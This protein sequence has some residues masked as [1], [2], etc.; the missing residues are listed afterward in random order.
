M[1]KNKRLHLFKFLVAIILI[2]PCMFV[3]SA[4][5]KQGEKG[6][7]G[8]QG[9]QG[10][11]GDKGDNGKDAE[12][13]N[14]YELYLSAKESGEF[15]G[16]YLD[17]IKDY[18]D[19]VYDNSAVVANKAVAST[20]SIDAYNGVKPAKPTSGSGVIFSLDEDGNAFIVT[21]YHVTYYYNP[22]NH[23]AFK[24]YDIYLYGEISDNVIHATYVGGSQT[25]DLAV[26]Y[27]SNSEILKNSNAQSI[28][29]STG[30][31]ILGSSVIASGNANGYGL[32]VTKGIIS[33]DSE[34]VYMT[35]AG[36]R[37]LYRVLRHDA[38]I[39]NGSSGGGLFDMKG[40]LVGITNGGDSSSTSINYAI[41]ADIVYAVATNIIKNCGYSNSNFSPKLCNLGVT[42]A[43]SDANTYYDD[44]NGKTSVTSKITIS[45]L[46]NVTNENL[47]A[48]AKDDELMS[49]KITT[50]NGTIFTKNANEFAY[51]NNILMQNIIQEF[52]LLADSGS[53]I[54][55]TV[56]RN[57]ETISATALVSDS[58]FMDLA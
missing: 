8:I 14:L 49:I 30:K 24:N 56:Q 44:E 1:K 46:E 32:A 51:T 34:A 39:T 47:K 4:C 17:F 19:V 2:V 42:F 52:L 20:V 10:E 9:I 54:E 3:F 22:Y 55:I 40:N 50:E 6:E 5:G 36:T 21:N 25:Y 38:Y 41:P 26:L 43:S 27:V 16:T 18:I 11:K 33:K 48:L 29:L 15:T 58:D 28:S 35:I 45:G 31:A 13:L 7:Q 23:N 57:G 53:T 12:Q 37:S